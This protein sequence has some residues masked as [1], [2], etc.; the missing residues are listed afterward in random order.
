MQAA[1]GCHTCICRPAD[2]NDASVRIPSDAHAWAPAKILAQGPQRNEGEQEL[3]LEWL[4]IKFNAARS[5]TSRK[6][7]LA[8]HERFKGPLLLLKGRVKPLLSALGSTGLL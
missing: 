6:H 8:Q 2:Q 3:N 5:C 4:I 1:R 7:V